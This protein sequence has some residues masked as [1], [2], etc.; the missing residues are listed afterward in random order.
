[1]ICEVCGRPIR[2]NPYPVKIEGALMRVCEKCAKYGENEAPRR[3]FNQ[4]QARGPGVKPFSS[5]EPLPSLGSPRP[6]SRPPTLE[7]LEVVENFAEI[8]R[9]QRRKYGMT[10]EEFGKFLLE[11]SSLINKIEM[12]K[13]IPPHKTI[14]KIERKLGLKLLVPRER[15]D[16]VTTTTTVKES[17][18]L[19]DIA[20]IKKKS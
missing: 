12:G 6:P 20:R 15:F 5:S 7:E 1:M 3:D 19:G 8:M 2:G 18:R 13:R 14:R 9:E 4:T 17:T 10:Q 11:R 16:G